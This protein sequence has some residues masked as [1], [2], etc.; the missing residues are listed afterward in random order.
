VGL[1]CGGHIKL[2]VE[3]A[4]PRVITTIQEERAAGRPVALE[5]DLGSGTSAILTGGSVSRS[6][7]AGDGARFQRVWNPPLRMVIVGAVHVAQALAK[8]A[9][10]TGFAVTIVDPRR[11]FATEERFPGVSMS[12]R[13]PDKALAE[14]NLDRRTAVVTL[15]HDPKLDD[16]ALAAALR[17]P[18]FFIGALGSKKTHAARV[19]RLTAEGLDAATIARIRGPVGLAIGARTASEIA[20]SILAQVVQELRQQP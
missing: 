11:A 9:A 20:V 15:T 14:L 18:A 17:S 8:L 3:R 16:P 19:E 12:T 5:T 10:V 6:E 2:W 1:A 7:S 4:D 13:W